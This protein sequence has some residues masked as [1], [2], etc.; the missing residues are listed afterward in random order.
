MKKLLTALLSAAI[1]TG[2]ASALTAGYFEKNKNIDVLYV[3]SPEGLRV[4]NMPDLIGKKTGVLFDRM[5]VKVISIGHEVSIDG[6]KSN[7]VKILLPVESLKNDEQVYGYVFGGYL[8][9]SLKPFS[10]EGWTDADLNRYL[11]RFSWVTGERN[12]REFETGGKYFTGR[13]ESGAGGSGTYKASMKNKKITVSVA[14]G[15]EEGF[16]SP[17]TEIYSIKEIKEDCLTLVL[18][19]DELL[20]KPAF[21][22]S[23]FYWSLTTEKTNIYDFIESSFNALFYP[24]ASDMVKSIMGG[25]DMPDFLNN[26]IK[27]G[28]RLDI[29]GYD[30][31]YRNYW[32]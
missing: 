2:T 1:M 18:E 20:L 9:D 31:K 11:S 24:F 6:I 5:A 14:Y 15:D 22:N 17:V 32:K 23:V 10:T 12:Y 16:G 28:V 4:R 25:K 19:G 13:L 8:T 29:E 30:D 3:D 26:L 7:W 21:T 27:A